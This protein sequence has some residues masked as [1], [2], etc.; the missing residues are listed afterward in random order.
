MST[1]EGPLMSI[2]T[3]NALSHYTDWTIGHVHSGALGWVGFISFGAI[4]CLVPWLWKKERLYSNALVEWHFWI[5]TTGIVLYITAMWVSGIMEGLMWREY[6]PDG[7]LANSFIETV[8]A[9]HIQNVIRTVGGLM[10]LS[11][12]L[13]MSYNL[14]RTIRMPSVPNSSA[15]PAT[16]I[17]PQLLPAE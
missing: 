5:A 8:S 3:V 16:T 11:G 17:Q 4:Y 12:T 1:F 2:R 10:F 15:V 13:I 6:T 9:K 14:W 7:F